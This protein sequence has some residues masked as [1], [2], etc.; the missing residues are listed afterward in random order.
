ML[1]LEHVSSGYGKKQVLFD[2]SFELKGG[3]VGLLVGSN[4]SG[5]STVLKTI[6]GLIPLLDKAYGKVWFNGENITGLQTSAL[7][8]KGILYVPQSNFCFETLTVQENLEI[9]GVTLARRA[10]YRER[11]DYAIGL[12]PILKN[13]LKSVA[14]RLSGGERQLLALAMASLHRPKMI[15]VDEPFAGLSVDNREL[16]KSH[17]QRLNSIEGIA[18]LLVEHRISELLGLSCQLIG[19]KMGKVHSI[20]QIRDGLVDSKLLAEILI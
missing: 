16:V 13:S 5:K 12:F 11:F 1:T 2:V 20:Q 19:L 15:L 10:Q 17:L 7:L 14:V 8:G 18:V 3:E 4:G 9:S 6:Y